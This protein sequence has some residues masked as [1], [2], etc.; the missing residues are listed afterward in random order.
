L[1]PV[2]SYRALVAIGDVFVAYSWRVTNKKMRPAAWRRPMQRQAN[3]WLRAHYFPN[4]STALHS[5]LAIAC[6]YRDALRSSRQL[7]VVTIPSYRGRH[8]GASRSPRWRKLWKFTQTRRFSGAASQ[9]DAGGA[10][11]AKRRQFGAGWPWWKRKT[12]PCPSCGR[13]AR[14]EAS[15]RGG[16]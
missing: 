8:S 12:R 6:A 16:A 14:N 11:E 3:Q 15:S 13:R 9:L 2:P 4:R 5:S 1:V 7:R 10:G